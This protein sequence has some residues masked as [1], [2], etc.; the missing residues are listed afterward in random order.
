MTAS[1]N[2]QLLQDVFAETAKGNGRPFVAA[3][4]EEI[5]WTII[6]ST[7]WSKT[8]RGK[9]SVVAD[10]LGPLR[11]Q[12]ANANTISAHRFIAEND[13]VV[14]EGRGHNTTLDIAGDTEVFVEREQS[15]DLL[16]SGANQTHGPPVFA[17]RMKERLREG[18]RCF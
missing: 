18:A 11:A 13:L 6:G 12:L 17:S 14:V 5:V 1:Q 2:K 8:Y 15:R 3:L 7:P 16:L 9:E 4:S 10:L